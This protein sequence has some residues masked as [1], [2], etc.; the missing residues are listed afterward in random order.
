MKTPNYDDKVGKH[1]IPHAEG[2]AKNEKK[3]GGDKKKD[4]NNKKEEGK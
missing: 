4:D 2:I 1:P 3:D